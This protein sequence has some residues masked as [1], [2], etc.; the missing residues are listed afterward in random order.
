MVVCSLEVGTGTL[1]AGAHAAGTGPQAGGAVCLAALPAPVW[2]AVRRG[3]EAKW[4]GEG[5]GL[6]EAL[7]GAE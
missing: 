3:G 1:L 6:E 5:A 7:Q 2:T 4:P